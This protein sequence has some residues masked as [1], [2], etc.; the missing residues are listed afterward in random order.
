MRLFAMRM[1]AIVAMVV[2]YEL[3]T[4]IG[5][6]TLAAGSAYAVLHTRKRRLE[7]LERTAASA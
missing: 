2:I 1:V 4:V 5:F 3:S 6:L 7:K